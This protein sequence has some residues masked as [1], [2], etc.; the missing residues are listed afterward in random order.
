M[1]KYNYYLM[2]L[3]SVVLLVI[4]SY[5]PLIG[6]VMAF[7]DF[8]SKELFFSDFVGMKHF[9]YLFIQDP[10]FRSVLM[11]TIIIILMKTIISFPIPIII[12]LSVNE[13]K[14]SYSRRIIQTIISIPYFI[15]W[16]VVSSIVI[17][18]LSVEG[19]LNNILVNSGIMDKPVPYLIKPD[20]FRIILVS[21]D[22]W[23]TAGWNTLIYLTAISSINNTYYESAEIGGAGRLKKMWYI[24]LPLIK[25]VI[26]I[27]FI[28]TLITVIDNTFEQVINLYNP[29]VYETGDILDTYIYRTGIVQGK[30]SIATAS[31]LVKSLLKLILLFSVFIV[32]RIWSSNDEKSI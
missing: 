32:T 26:V 5:V 14:S 29:A 11:N 27:V 8:S 23:K 21:S 13:L 6:L 17:K 7:Q 28:L 15:S 30:F 2:L 12:A 10:N 4:F 3:P 20:Y 16:V 18:F 1:K 9:Y 31:G 24:T 22:I 25:P 19:L